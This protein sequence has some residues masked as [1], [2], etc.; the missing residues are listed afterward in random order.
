MGLPFIDLSEVV[1]SV[2]QVDPFKLRFKLRVRSDKRS[3]RP[4]EALLF[5][6]MSVQVLVV[7]LGEIE[8]KLFSFSILLVSPFDQIIFGLLACNARGWVL[9][10]HPHDDI[11]EV[12]GNVLWERFRLLR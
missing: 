6:V 9:I 7:C 5:L 1:V 8:N 3:G 11:C 2:P 10:K 4:L 12:L